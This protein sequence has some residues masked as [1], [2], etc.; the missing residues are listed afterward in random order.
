MKACLPRKVD[1]PYCG[2]AEQILLDILCT[3]PTCNG[4]DQFFVAV[5]IGPY[6]RVTTL[7]P[8]LCTLN[9]VV[10]S[11]CD[12]SRTKSV[13]DRGAFM[14]V[15]ESGDGFCTPCHAVTYCVRPCKHEVPSCCLLLPPSPSSKPQP[16][17]LRHEHCQ[18]SVENTL[19][20]MNFS[21]FIAAAAKLRRPLRKSVILAA[22]Q[23]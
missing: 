1:A 13:T 20:G 21:T 15:H 9:H 12:L 3:N 4:Q 23:T 5:P 14:P 10:S 17:S 6:E 8:A 19:I 11:N 2:R 18:L 16:R 7:L 22:G